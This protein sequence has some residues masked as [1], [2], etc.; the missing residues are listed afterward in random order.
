MYSADRGGH[1]PRK[2]P[3]TYRLRPPSQPREE[4]LRARCHLKGGTQNGSPLG[5]PLSI[6]VLLRPAYNKGGE[7][8]SILPPCS[9]QTPLKFGQSPVQAPPTFIQHVANQT[10]SLGGIARCGGTIQGKPVPRD[11][12]HEFGERKLRNKHWLVVR[13]ICREHAGR[14]LAPTIAEKRLFRHSNYLGTSHNRW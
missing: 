10:L 13:N 11:E 5:R 8:Q 12:H 9:W 1:T 3:A 4:R 2:M 6:E 7:A 14:Y